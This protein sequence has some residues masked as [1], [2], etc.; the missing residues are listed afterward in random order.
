M[1]VEKA[2]AKIHDLEDG[3]MKEI[4]LGKG[5][6][7]LLAKVDGEFHA[8]GAYCSHYGAP[9]AKGALGQHMVVCP[10]HH[11][12][13]N[14]LTGDMAE[15][16]GLDGLPHYD[17]KVVGEDVIVSLPDVFKAQ[18]VMDMAR[19]NPEADTRTF[20]ILGG[21]AAGNAAAETLRQDGFQGRI[22]LISQEKES[23]YDR[24]HLSKGYMRKK[25]EVSDAPTLRSNG[26]YLDHGI[27]LL[28][29]RK[30]NQV[31]PSFNRIE[32]EGGEVLNYD[33]LLLATGGTPRR[34]DVPGADLNNILLLRTYADARRIAE[35]ST[36]TSKVV[37]IGAS[38]IGTEVAAGMRERGLDVTVVSMHAHPLAEAMGDEIGGMFQKIQ[39]SQGVKYEFNTQVERFE[40][41]DDVQSVVLKNGKTLEADFV[42]VA[43][44]ITPVTDYLEGID[45]NS[46]G[47]LTV[48]RFMR[49]PGTENLYA[50][51]DIATFPDWRTG[52]SIRVEHWR[53]AQQHGRTA[54]HNMSGHETEFRAVPFFWTTQFKLG[55]RYVGYADRWDEIIFHGRPEDRQFI[56]YYVQNNQILA[57]AGVGED[58]KMAAANE[59]MRENGLPSVEELRSGS[60][61]LLQRLKG[62]PVS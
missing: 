57:V 55:L 27:E 43:I 31:D 47:S 32:F 35:E 59:L 10:W 21:G 25:G 38:F 34:L 8:I 9:L 44:G 51:G 11:T 62:V 6:S 52:R 29:G 60:V 37:I 24:P 14:L 28:M 26:F 56:A 58:A 42:L 2:I 17:L 36:H 50:A 33:A 30:V 54:A 4:E 5:K 3:Q 20:V 18:R 22:V 12:F 46:D 23:P 1:T 48:D 61:D 7:L 53:L 40:G 39:E 41:R 49:V 13:F 16:P 15:P 19:Y 45:K